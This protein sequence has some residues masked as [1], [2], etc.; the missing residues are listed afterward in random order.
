MRSTVFC[1]SFSQNMALYILSNC[2]IS[3]RSLLFSRRP[4]TASTV[5]F[6]T[7]SV[8]F[9]SFVIASVAESFDLIIGT[10]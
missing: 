6:S 9:D 7:S 1:V 2:R 4:V 5:C 10:V 3:F 8:D